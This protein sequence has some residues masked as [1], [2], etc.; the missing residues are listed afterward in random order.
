MVLRADPDVM[1]PVR[2]R[3]A[4]PRKPAGHHRYSRFVGVMK[5]ALP[6]SAVVL[7]GLV[8]WP[9]L[10]RDVDRFQIGFAALSPTSVETLSMVNAHYQG[11]DN[12]NRPYTLT[13][14]RATETSSK[15]GIVILDNPKA[16]FLTRKGT[17]IYVE[18]R[19]GIYY[20]ADKILDLEGEVSLYQDEGNE[21][22]TERARVH[23]DT[24]SVEGDM[25]VTGN[26]PQGRIAGTGF[27]IDDNGRQMLLTGRSE[28]QMR[29]ARRK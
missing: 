23:L 2:R 3:G 6:A 13:A 17:G 1:P 24:S 25:P 14:E 4:H 21:M 7:L 10:A 18:A 27:R 19:T 28:V 12:T 26:G 15:S 5:V 16:D 20:Q 29:G 9:K 11:L 8:V 22:H